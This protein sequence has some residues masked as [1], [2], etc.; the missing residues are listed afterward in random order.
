MAIWKIRTLSDGVTIEFA[1]EEL[2]K[3]TAS[4]NMNSQN[5][6]G[7]N[8]SE[9]IL[10]TVHDIEGYEIFNEKDRSEFQSWTEDG[11][12]ILPKADVLYIIGVNERSVLFG[13][14][15]FCKD[16]LGYHWVT[17]AD[18]QVVGSEKSI[19]D[20]Y[21]TPKFKRRGFVIE[22][23][24][25]PQF[26]LKMV[27]WLAK[28]YIN[29][30]FFTFYLWDELQ[31]VL[32][33]ELEKRGMKVTLGGHSLSFLRGEKST[34][35]HKQL[36]FGDE[37]W[38]VQVIKTIKGFCTEGSPVT[39]ISLW[40]EDTGV[41]DESLLKDYIRFTEQIKKHLPNLNVEHIA[42]NAGLSWE[43]LE[44]GKMK[45]TSV[46][47]DTLYAFW[48][49]NYN[50]PIDDHVRAYSSLKS[51]KSETSKA[52]RDLTVFEYYSDHF[53]L[54]DLFPPLFNRI[55]QDLEDYSS[56]GVNGVTNLVVP[57]KPKK[58]NLAGTYDHVYPWRQIQLMNGFFFSRLSWGDT[59]EEVENEFYG[60]YGNHLRPWMKAL[61]NTLSKA[62]KWNIPL[63]PSRL[64]DPEQVSGGECKPA[65]IFHL[66]KMQELIYSLIKDEGIPP[67]DV[68][69]VQ[70]H[71]N[72]ASWEPSDTLI[73]YLL[74]LNEKL[75]EYS[76]KWKNI[77]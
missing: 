22:T 24:N 45:S 38:Q 13:V 54:S 42:Y 57:Y 43:M 74:F 68:W 48:G 19:E 21:H 33:E 20:S 14:Y 59:F 49:R 27:D 30:V 29:E 64:M 4:H 60:T 39:R 37:T 35:G 67:I 25:E 77:T 55:K 73:F 58:E 61:E 76:E 71:N 18:G 46:H 53:M 9:I 52:G 62:S 5:S 36:D 41:E 15:Q 26:M 23:I 31:G 32:K 17:L 16:V 2:R 56:I 3:Y 44:I 12:A 34:P 6:L 66:E 75:K 70:Q 1:A 8:T 47:V 40:P 72:S 65:A 50:Q 10:A 7:G 28:Q 11:F 69:L 51:W 63:F